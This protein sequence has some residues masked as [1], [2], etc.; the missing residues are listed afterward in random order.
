[1]KTKFL[2]PHCRVTLNPG[3]GI[4]L[5]VRKGDAAGLIF[6]NPQPG[7]YQYLCDDEF[8]ECLQEGD[9][10]DFSCPVCSKPLT[11]PVSEKLAE[12]VINT[13]A[14]TPAGK[15]AIARFSRI[16]G[17][18]ATFVSTGE[19]IASY[20]EHTALFQ[21]VDFSKFDWNW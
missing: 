3:D 11:S 21:N 7:N 5:S 1:M 13:P 10:V 8:G 12:I 6:L 2:C 16:C 9:A 15:L 14:E 17:E 18:H 19:K 20:G 4:V